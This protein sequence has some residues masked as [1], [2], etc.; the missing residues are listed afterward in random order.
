MPKL[1][2]ITT[3]P[4]SLNLLLSGQMKYMKDKGWEVIAVSSDG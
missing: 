3:V 1:I 4:L 2:R